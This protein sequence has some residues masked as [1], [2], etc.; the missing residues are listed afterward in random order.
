MHFERVSLVWC[1]PLLSRFKLGTVELQ[2]KL[3]SS[4]TPGIS[5]D[6]T[7]SVIE[8]YGF[9][10]SLAVGYCFIFCTGGLFLYDLQPVNRNYFHRFFQR[11]Y[12]TWCK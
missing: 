8:I 5:D 10:F 9:F 2:P 12:F 1:V 3:I 11:L 7:A 6:V 4:D